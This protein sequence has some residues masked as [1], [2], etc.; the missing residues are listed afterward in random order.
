M[1]GS[2]ALFH[3]FYG[4]REELRVLTETLRAA[5]LDG[6]GAT[7]LVS[8]DAGVG[9]TRLVRELAHV[10]RSERS[11]VL[12]GAALEYIRTPYGPIVEALSSDGRTPAEVLSLLSA[13]PADKN[14]NA[15]QDRLRRFVGVEGFLRRR[16]AAGDP[17][18]L[19]VE[20]LHW[21]DASTLELL[22]YLT[23]RLAD[24]GVVMIATYRTVDIEADLPRAGSVVRLLREGAVGLTLEPLARGDI[25]TA[26]RATVPA[27]VSIAKTEIEEICDLAEGRPYVAEELL[28]DAI[29]R[30]TQDP[31]SPHRGH[32]VVISLRTSVLERLRGFED[33]DRELMLCAAVVGREFDA[34][35]LT[36]IL[37]RPLTEVQ[38]TL[39]RA[40]SAQLIVDDERTGL[41]AFRHAITR[42]V[43]YQELLSSERRAL[44]ARIA[45]ALQERDPEAFA[46][47]ISYHWWAARSPKAVEWNEWAGDRASAIHAY[48]DAAAFY[49]RALD[50]IEP[51]NEGYPRILQAIA[52]ALCTSGEIDRARAF[53]EQAVRVLR[54]R[55]RK[56][57]ALR[58]ML[59]VAR[60]YYEIG[61]VEN[62]L[63][64]TELVRSEV[65][66]TPVDA[67][68]FAAETTLAAIL[69]VQGRPDE[70][71]AILDRASAADGQKDKTDLCR[72]A[73]ARGLA[74]AA[75]G[76]F[77][78]CIASYQRALRIAEE[79][80]RAD[81]M[82][83]MH[84]NISNVCV[85]LGRM[86]L[87]ISSSE[88]AIA[89][90]E[91]GKHTRTLVLLKADLAQALLYMG[92]VSRARE[93]CT[94]VQSSRHVSIVGQLTTRAVDLRL[95][96][97]LLG[98][99]MPS[100]EEL[101]NA[102]SRALEYGESQMIAGVGGAVAEAQ[103]ASGD[104]AAAATTLRRVFERLMSPEF[105]YAVFDLAASIGTEADIASARRLLDR[106]AAGGQNGAALAHRLLFDARCSGRGGDPDR[107]RALAT[108]AAA[109]FSELPWPLEAAAALEVAGDLDGALAIYRRVGASRLVRRL[110]DV[111]GVRR[112]TQTGAFGALSRREEQVAEL[113]VRGHAYRAIGDELGIGERTV[114]THAKSIY[115]KLGVKTRFD[116]A[117]L[118]ERAG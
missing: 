113:L 78:D 63:K 1:V 83:H 50:L 94:E 66:S 98:V 33:S 2:R 19:I 4:R 8:G 84:G 40:Q 103:L 35:L 23:H 3:G 21:S 89:I 5:R 115:R 64:T 48:A 69:A 56:E 32:S 112:S 11:S 7:I 100:P 55:G 49:E 87:A 29:V 27:G 31:N 75:I 101:A 16:A 57:A 92:Q 18:V 96:T 9:K 24:A 25:A 14:L 118:R 60:Q 10:A 105:G 76:A 91:A 6:R 28:R 88:R 61:D 117:R 70:S 67:V 30:A 62:A 47:E 86:E 45:D 82:A 110:E 53:C 38:R 44:H 93:V 46:A 51:E 20:D 74:Q 12:I 90:A 107:C 108:Q 58:Q 52:F 26:I 43:L 81:L 54:V 73:N 80:D 37:D 41:V 102:L 111:Q 109:A 72:A 97:L 77:D 95:R 15:E 65:R 39:R 99:E 17:V 116:L 68:W 85:Y 34:A 106:A 59:Y 114:E 42:E 104:E 13:P 22:L 79:L 71:I 36:Q